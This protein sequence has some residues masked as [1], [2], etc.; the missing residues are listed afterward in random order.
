MTPNNCASPSYDTQIRFK[1]LNIK[2]KNLFEDSI[3]QLK[4]NIEMHL[5]TK[6]TYQ[7]SPAFITF[8][9]VWTSG[10]FC[11]KFKPEIIN[12]KKLLHVKYIRQLSNR[13]N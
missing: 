1:Y 10:K 7:V 9:N 8:Q 5:P 2:M 3:G 6:N 13:T 4:I 11:H 12:K